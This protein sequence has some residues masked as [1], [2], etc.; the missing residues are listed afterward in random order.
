MMRGAWILFGMVVAVGLAGCSGD[1]SGQETDA[2]AD[3]GVSGSDADS[4]AVATQ[5][6]PFEWDGSVGTGAYACGPAGCAGSGLPGGW[7][8]ALELDGLVA[9]DVELTFDALPGQ[10][11]AFGLATACDGACDFVTYAIGSGSIALSADGLDPGHTYTLVAWHPYQSAMAG[12]A[13]AGVETA[14]RVVG[15]LAVVV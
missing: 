11:L 13:Q 4:T 14:F 9:L 5:V 15:E 1:A 6:Q 10:E 7:E 8:Q 2:T 12:G 3:L